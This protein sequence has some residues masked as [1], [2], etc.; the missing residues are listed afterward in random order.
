[1]DAGATEVGSRSRRVRLGS[2]PIRAAGRK[3]LE[4]GKSRK[5]TKQSKDTQRYDLNYIKVDAQLSR[6][7]SGTLKCYRKGD[8]FRGP[9][10]S[11]CITLR[12][13]LS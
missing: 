10:M 11:S 8:P 1:M 7:P 5:L 6:H 4:R 3:D 9:G 13:E 2:A 12:T